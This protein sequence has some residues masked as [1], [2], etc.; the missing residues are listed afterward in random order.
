MKDLSLA[1][2]IFG[3]W[4]KTR[5]IVTVAIGAALYGVLMIYGGIPVFTNTQ[6]STAL[7][8]PIFVGALTGAFPTA[9]AL[10]LGNVIAD[11]IGGW[12]LWFDWSIGNAVMGFFVGLLPVYGAY[13][14]DGIFKVKHAIIYAI[15]VAV[16]VVV[17]FAAV[18]PLLT[19]VMYAGE[20]QTSITQG[21]VAS[22]ANIA[23]LIVLGIPILALMANRFG[24]RTN[25][26]ETE[27]DEE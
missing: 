16:G 14:M 26:R 12:G 13:I 24:A 25:L 6:L 18:T 7:L 17:A 10:F 1:K 27:S 2:K 23:I 22:I 20:L 8:V 4:K 9:I 19:M 21:L 5:T 3:D 15:T 11:L